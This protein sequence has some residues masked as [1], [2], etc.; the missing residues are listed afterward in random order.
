MT[1]ERCSQPKQIGVS[2]G[3]YMRVPCSVASVLLCRLVFSLRH[4]A[5]VPRRNY[6]A[7]YEAAESRISTKG[8]PARPEPRV[9]VLPL[10]TLSTLPSSPGLL[11]AGIS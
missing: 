8:A 3:P 9:R 11:P 4:G 5:A 1:P 7:C 10:A 2:C 6:L